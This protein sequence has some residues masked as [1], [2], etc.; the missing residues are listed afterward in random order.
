MSTAAVQWLGQSFFKIQLQ[1]NLVILVDPWK[2]FTPGNVLFPQGVAIDDA[3]MILV[4]HGHF[5]HIGDTVALAKAAT[6]PHF[7]VLCNFEIMIYLLSQGVPQ[8]KLQSM[9]IGGTVTIQGVR[10]SMV[11]A[12]HSSG[13]GGFGPQPLLEGGDAAGFVIRSE[14]SPTIYHAGDTDLNGDM[15]LLADRYEP[16]VSILPIGGI[17]TMDPHDAAL[18][19]RM[20]R[21]KAVFPAHYGGTFKLPGTPEE[22]TEAMNKVAPQ[23]AVHA[24]KPGEVVT[25]TV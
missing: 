24:P 16:Y 2:D 3:D 18:A 14:Q 23:V 13:I 12:R 22:F 6:K 25:I 4:T 1:N 5:D 8:E 17:F 20:L 11:Y 15:A 9:N 7:K 10:I 19:A 21:S